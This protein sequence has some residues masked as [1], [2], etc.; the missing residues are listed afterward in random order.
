M[1]FDG[2]AFGAEIVNVVKGYLEREL[3]AVAARLDAM[4]KRI[5]ALPAPVDLSADLAAVKAAVEAIE[6]PEIPTLPELPD[7]A[8]MIDDALATRL[9]VEDMEKSIEDVVRA[10]L[11]EIPYPKDG[12]P[13]KSVTIEDVMPA[14]ERRVEAHLTA[15]PAPKDGKSVT[16]EDVAPLIAAEVE[17]RVSS[18]PKPKD[19]EPGRD[20]LDVKE[21]FRAEG[22]RLVAVM[23]DGTTRDLGVF[24]GKDGEPG[25]PGADAVGFDDLDVSY[26]GEKTITLKF[27]KGEHVK[28]FSFAMPVVIDRGVYREGSEYKA[29]DA[30]TWGGSLWIAQKE[31]AAK[32]DAG[33]DWRLSV[34][35]GRDGK[36][37]TVKE[38]KR[39]EP[40]RV[41]APA[42]GE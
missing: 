7:F 12:E 35:R 3:A 38:T 32:P 16:V 6:I 20:G 10:V 33:D 4:E 42:R 1:S 40:L 13:G 24:V 31:T 17:K 21:M 8:K 41:G 39:A 11:A 36:D 23:S 34:K 19:G 9:D 30:V 14:I 18:L 37:G 25:K 26:D 28:E 2:K 29:G 15:I 5:E 22:G 27:T